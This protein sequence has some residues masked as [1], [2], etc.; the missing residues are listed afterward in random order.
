MKLFFEGFPY[1]EAKL[2]QYIGREVDLATL[3]DNLAK[4]PYVGYYFNHEINDSVF[5]LPKV[6]ISENGKA[7]DRYKPDEIIDISP[8]NNPLHNDRYTDDKVVFELSAWLYRAINHF[9]E[10]KVES[11]IGSEV[12]IQNVRPTGT[13]TSKTII[14]T[15]L[16]LLDFNKRHRNLFTYIAIVNASGNNKVHWTKT[17]SK[18]QPVFQDDAPYYLKFQNKNK[19][20]DFDE[21]LISLFYSVL[22]YLNATYHFKVQDVQ[23]YTLLKPAR[24]KSMIDSGKGT[25]LLKKIR[26]NYFTDELVQLWNLLFDFFER[27]EMVASGR[28]YHERLLVNNFNLIFEDMIDQIISDKD[29]PTE[30]KEQK[31]GK[32]VDHLY[33]APSIVEADKRIYYIGDSKYYKEANAVDGKSIYKQF[34]YAKNVIQYNINLFNEKKLPD[35]FRYRDDLTEGY[36]LTPNF[37]I[38]GVIDFDNPGSQEWKIKKDETVFPPNFH[39]LNRLFDRDT[40]F[41]QSYDINFMFVVAS[42]V[43]NSDDASLK[44]SLREMFRTDFINFLK[45]KFKFYKLTPHNSGEEELK[46]AVERNFKNLIGKIYKPDN[47]N[48]LILALDNDVEFEAKN[49][50]LLSKIREDF[51]ADKYTLGAPLIEPKLYSPLEEPLRIAADPQAPYGKQMEFDL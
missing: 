10:R 26:R 22:H 51:N 30:L 43:R 33:Q 48:V 28:P 27:A 8:D 38:R 42:Y 20:I 1:T 9:Y 34:T 14:E 15:I 47:A 32:I 45:D 4:I 11:R 40:L 46:K 5:I 31:D 35:Y 49:K 39:F 17:V 7:F 2:R 25:R 29:V 12:H 21:E 41:L 24:I 37:F 23:G 18:I 50:E 3:N 19:V 44:K 13:K 16:S 36:N 6:F